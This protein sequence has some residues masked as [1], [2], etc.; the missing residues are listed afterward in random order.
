[1]GRGLH[2]LPN[3]LELHRK[4]VRI[5]WES[6]TPRIRRIGQKQ[7]AVLR[8]G[9]QMLVAG[10]G[11]NA[12]NELQHGDTLFFLQWSSHFRFAVSIDTQGKSRASSCQ[13]RQQ[14]H[15]SCEGCRRGEAGEGTECVKRHDFQRSTVLPHDTTICR[16]RHVQSFSSPSTH[17]YPLLLAA[18]TTF[19][20][21]QSRLS[22]PVHTLAPRTRPSAREAGKVA[23]HAATQK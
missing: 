15:G 2:S 16:S 20:T 14:P 11:G 23:F 8:R 21:S 6:E 13:P 17:L 5:E 22:A 18:E 12:W 10:P 9:R 7:V 1:M 3:S 19:S 4:H